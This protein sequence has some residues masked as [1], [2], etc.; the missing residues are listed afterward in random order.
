MTAK[1]AV[2]LRMV[3]LPDTHFS[4]DDSETPAQSFERARDTEGATRSDAL[5]SVTEH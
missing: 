1:L 3:V 4:I 2:W 5:F